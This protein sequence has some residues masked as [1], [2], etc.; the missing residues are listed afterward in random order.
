M[1]E[2]ELRIAPG[3]FASSLLKFLWSCY[4]TYIKL[5]SEKSMYVWEVYA[6]GSTHHQTPKLH[7]FQR[8]K[9]SPD[10]QFWATT[11]V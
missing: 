7:T 8:T 5:P 3:M 11:R 9:V 4:N 1:I 2:K 10:D 6:G